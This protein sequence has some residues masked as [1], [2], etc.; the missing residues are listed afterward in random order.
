MSASA[1][2]DSFFV[3]IVRCVDDS[4]Y[5]GHTS[6][7]KERVNTHNEGRGASWIACRRPVQLVYHERHDSE[8]KAVARERQIKRWTH[9]KS[10]PSS[11]ETE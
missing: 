8:E 7:L 9:D 1:P 10:W 3:Y 6:D 2:A 5:V 4:F 11:K